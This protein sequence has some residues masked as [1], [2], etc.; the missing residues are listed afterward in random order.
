MPKEHTVKI[1]IATEDGEVLDTVIVTDKQLT[2]V[3]GCSV[4]I[5]EIQGSLSILKARAEMEKK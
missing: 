2:T 5:A 3:M 4:V 1:I